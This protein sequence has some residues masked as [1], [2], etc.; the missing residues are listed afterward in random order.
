M[1]STTRILLLPHNRHKRKG[2]NDIYI[3]GRMINSEKDING[4][5]A[6]ALSIF[7]KMTPV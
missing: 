1:H 2:G 5:I 4:R 6:K 7:H 3:K